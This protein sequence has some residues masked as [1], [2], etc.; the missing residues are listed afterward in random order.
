MVLGDFCKQQLDVFSMDVV[1][2]NEV[3]KVPAEGEYT[4]SLLVAA[5]FASWEN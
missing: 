1:T 4:Q 5:A 2:E 3:A